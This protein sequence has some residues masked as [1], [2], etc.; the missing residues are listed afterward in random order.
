VRRS[1]QVREHVQTLWKCNYENPS[2]SNVNIIGAHTP[3]CSHNHLPQPLTIIISFVVSFHQP[4]LGEG[5]CQAKVGVLETWINHHYGQGRSV[6][7]LMLRIQ[8]QREREREDG[9]FRAL[10]AWP[11]CLHIEEATNHCLYQPGP[12][13]RD[14]KSRWTCAVPALREVNCSSRATGIQL[15]VQS[16]KYYY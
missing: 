1:R 7:S 12:C 15:S 13:N 5:N 6:P 14:S 8:T 16:T 4:V 9:P 10:H 11:G 2:E 3:T